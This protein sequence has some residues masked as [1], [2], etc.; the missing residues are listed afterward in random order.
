M[1]VLT[2]GTL[3]RGTLAASTSL[4]S[5]A[6]AI[7]LSTKRFAVNTPANTK[8]A[9]IV[10]PTGWQL[11][12]LTDLGGRL[13]LDGN[14]LTT[15]QQLYDVLTG[16]FRV[17]AAKGDGTQAIEQDFS[18]EIYEAAPAPSRPM[19]EVRDFSDN[20][21]LGNDYRAQSANKFPDFL[22]PYA[23]RRFTDTNEY[24][25]EL[26]DGDTWSGDAS[27]TPPRN[28]AEFQH[29]NKV[30]PISGEAVEYAFS[31]AVDND[32]D[33]DGPWLIFCQMHSG[34][35][36]ANAIV[37]FELAGSTFNIKSS[38]D[39]TPNTTNNRLVTHFT[40][41]NFKRKVYNNFVVR[42]RFSTTGD[43]M[44][45]VWRNGVLIVNAQNIMLGYG[46]DTRFS[47]YVKWGAYRRAS[48]QRFAL[49]IANFEGP[50]TTSLIARVTNPLPLPDDASIARP[51]VL[52]PSIL[53]ESFDSTANWSAVA[54]GSGS[55][56]VDAAGKD[57][58]VARAVL[59][60][61]PTGSP[62]VTKAVGLPSFDAANHKMFAYVVDNGEDPELNNGADL[63]LGQA[64]NGINYPSQAIVGKYPA[65]GASG[66]GN[67][68]PGK[69]VRFNSVADMAAETTPVRLVD[70]APLGVRAFGGFNSGKA[71]KTDALITGQGG[72]PTLVF[73]WDDGRVG[74]WTERQYMADRGI[75]STFCVPW[76]LIGQLN[77]L[78]LSQLQ[79]LKALGHDMQLDGARD[80]GAMIDRTDA[81]AVTAELLEGRQW[82]ADNGLNP[83]ARHFC[84][85][86]GYF[87]SAAPRFLL[88]G[89]VTD[90]SNIIKVSAHGQSR[91]GQPLF[92][93]GVPVGTW[94]TEAT[95]ATQLK[96]NKPI[97][98]GASKIWRGN[99]S[100]LA[101]VSMTAGSP[102]MTMASTADLVPGMRVV[103]GG[104]A[105]PDNATIL[106]VDSATQVTV[107]VGGSPVNST[108]TRTG[109]VTFTDTSHPF[110]TGKMQAPIKAA[111]FLTGRTTTPNPVFS[112]H[113][114]FDQ[115]LLLP[116][117]SLSQA[118][119]ATYQALIDLAK[120]YGC[121]ILCYG[122]DFGGGLVNQEVA[123]FRAGMDLVGSELA[124][125]NISVLTVDEWYMRDCA[126]PLPFPG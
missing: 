94:I 96:A 83:Y 85:T 33:S 11:T 25:F 80:D 58:G 124:A 121:T 76:A 116:A 114:I 65:L 17:R 72:V 4:G 52:P 18:V 109:T 57:Q 53:V 123:D 38:W 39:D 100:Q 71:A 47:P 88:P 60:P 27:V 93:D 55:F 22:K 35:S 59:Q 19:L 77:R 44:L 37:V 31:M 103:T 105:F 86:N 43:G 5:V 21:I 125:G 73:Y 26:R 67:Y 95:S 87:R 120:R 106:S 69:H 82:L 6:L 15:T 24:R 42:C 119:A 10:G 40:E 92:G 3:S 111:G 74:P 90:G 51:K 97:P 56:T 16:V 13:R 102:L 126:N 91:D 99:Y 122:H 61:G 12:L 110:H 84:Y 68:I 70:G 64:A 49:R 104:T 98:A 41:N 107:G 28:R 108:V 23:I 62:Q 75:R 101:N 89:L 2:R 1:S 66:A 48:A 50:S 79:D 46:A 14:D 30:L 112:K 29:R 78:T 20:V 63:R 36:N 113:G 117:Y 118:T 32:V 54:A 8:I 7:T 34:I 81:A 9:R 115:G 45:M